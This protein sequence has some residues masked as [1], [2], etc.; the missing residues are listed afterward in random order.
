MAASEGRLA[1]RASLPVLVDRS[2][3]SAKSPS[4][5]RFNQTWL[6]PP[7]ATLMARSQTKIAANMA[8]IVV[9]SDLK[10]NGVWCRTHSGE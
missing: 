7:Q 3:L 10:I 4:P 5:N 8:V 2:L 1:G 9:C 6:G